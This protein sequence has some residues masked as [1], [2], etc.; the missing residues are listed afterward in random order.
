M[1]VLLDTCAF[2]WIIFGSKELSP[3]AAELFAQPENDVFLS[4][5][6]CWEISVK[7]SLGRLAL[8]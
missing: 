7:W 1:N 3:T 6:S 2:L 4:A 5:A 8:P